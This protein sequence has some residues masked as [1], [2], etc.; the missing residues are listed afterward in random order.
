MPNPV[1]TAAYAGTLD[2]LADRTERGLLVLF[3][4]L[5][6][7]DPRNADRFH[8][9]AAPLVRSSA[10]AAISVSRSYLANITGAQITPPPALVVA[11]AA[12]R[13]Y[14]P[15]DRLGRNLNERM[16]WTEA[17]QGARSQ[18]AALGRGAVDRTNRQALSYMGIDMR[19]WVR[20]LDSDPCQWCMKLSSVVFDT[21]AQASFGHDRC[22][23]RPVPAAEV[24]DHNDR[25]R[26]ANNWDPEAERLFDTR[27]QRTSLRKQAR[28]AERRSRDAAQ[29]ALTEPDPR[30]RD[31]L[32]TRAQEWETRAEAANEQ[33]R[34]LETGTH[35]LAA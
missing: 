26:E 34:I 3:D 10:G 19:D 5:P 29:E 12:A 6:D 9:Q 35:R 23:C 15:F 16:P 31:R 30:R 18:V 25:L 33:L 1:L 21:A 17:V 7:Y 22:G 20:R 27:Q 8:A 28:N 2:R 32:E 24:G 13:L 11:D 4:R 14:D